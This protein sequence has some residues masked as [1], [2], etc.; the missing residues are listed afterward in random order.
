MCYAHLGVYGST[1][2][3]GVAALRALL[4]LALL[5]FGSAT[6]YLYE[7][8]TSHCDLNL[9]HLA[10]ILSWCVCL[11]ST[12]PDQSIVCDNGY[13]IV[14]K[15]S[16]YGISTHPYPSIGTFTSIVGGSDWLCSLS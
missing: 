7:L 13:M 3:F 4:T 16:I 1:K 8:F 15:T 11:V 2:I 14:G 9:L 5:L 10:G 6:N 12:I